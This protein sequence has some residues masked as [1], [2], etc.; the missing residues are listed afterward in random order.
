[1]NADIREGSIAP[2]AM[3]GLAMRPLKWHANRWPAQ[4]DGPSAAPARHAAIVNAAVGSWTIPPRGT[5]AR[6]GTSDRKLP[7]FRGSCNM[8]IASTENMA[9]IRYHLWAASGARVDRTRAS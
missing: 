3:L 2:T 9:A 7:P 8:T 1:M 5:L 4:G 6:T